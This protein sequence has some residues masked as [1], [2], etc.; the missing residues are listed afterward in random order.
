MNTKPIIITTIVES[1]EIQIIL[2][3]EYPGSSIYH[4]LIDKENHGMVRKVTRDWFVGMNAGSKLTDNDRD[5]I[6]RAVSSVEHLNN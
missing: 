4:I 6:V 3:P 2:S 5:A 1:E